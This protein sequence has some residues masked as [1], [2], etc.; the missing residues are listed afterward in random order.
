M[1]MKIGDVDV[2]SQIIENEYRIMVLENVIERLTAK[3]PL[4]GGPPISPQE[5]NEI[6]RS[7]VEQL[8]K[9][10]PNSGITLKEQKDE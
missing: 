8:Q 7:V 3:L 10:Y 5:M 6:R 2:A 9:K 4:L 1:G